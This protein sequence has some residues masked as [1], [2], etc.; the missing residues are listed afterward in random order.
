MT[1][2]TPEDFR[3]FLTERLSRNDLNSLYETK[4]FEK[5]TERFGDGTK[6]FNPLCAVTQHV[7]F[8][9]TD[10]SVENRKNYLDTYNWIARDRELQLLGFTKTVGLKSNQPTAR[11]SL[12]PHVI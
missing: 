9:V 5:E 8:D 3:T 1:L 11:R 6:H 7:G 4:C 12:D 10:A 2:K